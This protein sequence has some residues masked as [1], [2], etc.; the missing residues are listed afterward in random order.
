MPTIDVL[1]DLKGTDDVMAIKGLNAHDAATTI[2]ELTRIKNN[3]DSWWPFGTKALHVTAND[4][5][6][7]VIY[8]S[9]IAGVRTRW[10]GGRR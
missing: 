10:T 8:G 5:S 9:Q 7:T 4:G 3:A 6:S 2:L 1:V